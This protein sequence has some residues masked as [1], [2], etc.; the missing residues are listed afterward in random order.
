MANGILVGMVTKSLSQSPPPPPPPEDL[1]NAIAF[2]ETDILSFDSDF[3]L[4]FE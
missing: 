2:D 4:K 1:T 3:W